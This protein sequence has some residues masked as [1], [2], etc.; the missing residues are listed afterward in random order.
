MSVSVMTVRLS[1]PADAKTN[2][3][4]ETS[5]AQDTDNW[6]RHSRPP[7][8]LRYRQEIDRRIPVDDLERRASIDKEQ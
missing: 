1:Q 4:H 8:Q 6:P 5:A 7:I 2:Q 3:H